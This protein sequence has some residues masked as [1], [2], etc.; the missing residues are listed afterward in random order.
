M[1]R[2]VTP[3]SDSPVYRRRDITS[4][5]LAFRPTALLPSLCS[6]FRP[7]LLSQF[8]TIALCPA[9]YNV[10]ERATHGWYCVLHCTAVLLYTCNDSAAGSN[11]ATMRF[12]VASNH[13]A[14]TGLNRARDLL[15]PL[16]KKYA[17]CSYADLYTLAGTVDGP[18]IVCSVGPPH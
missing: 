8:F 17:G 18:K 15:E 5:H 9:R 4:F 7:R 12:S 1:D 13:G 11:G 6:L 3:L 10:L 14:N 2:R 16:K